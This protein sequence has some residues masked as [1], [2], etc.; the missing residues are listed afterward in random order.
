MPS[1]TRIMPCTCKSPNQDK[2]YGN[3]M[4]LWNCMKPKAESNTAVRC[5]VCLAQKEFSEK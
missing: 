2:L 4:R 3:D 1:G 5:T